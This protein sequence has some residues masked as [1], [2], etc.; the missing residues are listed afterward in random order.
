MN[1]KCR[2]QVIPNFKSQCANLCPILYGDVFVMIH[3]CAGK[4]LVQ[5]H[6]YRNSQRLRPFSVHFQTKADMA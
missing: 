5:E 6:E 3:I 2:G 4:I 1:V